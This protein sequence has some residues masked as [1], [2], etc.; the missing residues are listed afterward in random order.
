[1][2][3]EPSDFEPLALAVEKPRRGSSPWRW[4]LLTTAVVFI[5]IMG[6][7]L[8]A[9]SVQITVQAQTS[10]DIAL[11]GGLYLPFGDRY[12]LHTGDYQVTA[13]AMGYH[14]LHST[15]TVTDEDNQVV[16]LVLQPLPG[17]LSVNSQPFGAKVL[18]D[19]EL[20]GETPLSAVP[21]EAGE[22]SLRIQ[23]V[24]YLP[25]EQTLLVTGR[26]IQQHLELVLEPAWAEITVDSLPQGATVLVDGEAAG[27]TPVVLEILQGEHQLI[28]QKEGFAHWQEVLTVTASEAQDMGRVELQP[29]AATIQ[30][31]SLPNRA[32]VTVDGEFRGQTPLTLEV[33]PDHP[34]RLAVFKPGYRRHISSLELAAGATT[35]RTVKLVAQLGEVRFNIEPQDAILKINGQPR[36]RGSRTLALPAFEQ[37]VE[38]ALDGYASVR[39]R[40]T[41][42][43][44]LDQVVNIT[45][46]T[47]HEAQLSR[48]KPELTTSLGQTLL[49]FTPGDFTMGASRREPGRRA[50]EVLHPVSLTRL[51][52]LQTTEVTNAEFRLFQAS[53]NSGQIQGNSLN[54]EHQPVAQ[55]SWQQAAQFCNWLSQ[56]EGLAPFYQ[57]TNGV[58]S[59]YKRSATGYRLPTE[60]E[61]AWAARVDGETVLK[62]PWGDS[63]PPTEPVENYADSTSAYV[64]GRIIN[65][66]TDGHVVTA[67]VA[68]FPPNQK[69]LYDMGGNVAEWV[70]D[71]YSIP[72]DNGSTQVDPTGL[73]TGDNY[74]IR[75]AGWSH[76]K[77]AELR[78]SYRDYGQ[79]GRDDVGFRIARYA[80]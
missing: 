42:R 30:L 79:A 52:Y 29:A 32:N 36:G 54:R 35:S 23:A 38:V 1:M 7:L 73:Q 57:E 34:H 77:I 22:H 62:F 24:R 21:V 69:G 56:R 63:F 78:L 53:H 43:P 5:A 10:A 58:V 15:V 71:V 13:T 27:T 14:P 37:T 17:R 31:V 25:L 28:L 44:D 41:P 48:I 39:R 50:N 59:G 68:S 55:V 16:Q 46:Q 4:I 45:L 3:I 65:G 8:S 61:W 51:F 9:K 33:S 12:L 19:G 6:F 76:S 72:S 2:A 18:I 26:N 11:S 20:I 75:G 70:L 66:Y 40:V 80:E 74:V 64:T 67:A 49:L 60:A 47:E